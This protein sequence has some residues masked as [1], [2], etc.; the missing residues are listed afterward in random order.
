MTTREAVRQQ[1]K[2]YIT[3]I[4]AA[5]PARELLV[6]LAPYK[7]RK[8]TDKNSVSST[9][10]C[11]TSTETAAYLQPRRQRRPRHIRILFSLNINGDQYC[12]KWTFCPEM[13]RHVNSVFN[14]HAAPA[15]RQV[16]LTLLSA[17]CKS[18]LSQERNQF[19]ALCHPIQG[20]PEHEQLLYLPHLQPSLLIPTQ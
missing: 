16:F 3:K 14:P 10:T 19:F 18:I 17:R 1:R 15:Y 8:S 11:I 4:T 13:L 7:H 5:L 20:L 6:L 12:T 9:L 2:I